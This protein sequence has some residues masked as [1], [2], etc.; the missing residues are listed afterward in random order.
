MSFESFR[1]Q[2]YVSEIRP[3]ECYSRN[4]LLGWNLESLLGR[5]LQRDVVYLG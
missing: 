1:Q 3:N 4:M 5:G 2:Y